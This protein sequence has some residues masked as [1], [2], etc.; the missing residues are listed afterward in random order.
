MAWD[1]VNQSHWNSLL[2]TSSHFGKLACIWH[3]AGATEPEF[4]EAEPPEPEQ[5]PEVEAFIKQP[6]SE[7]PECESAGV[8]PKQQ[9]FLE[10][11]EPPEQPDP[12]ETEQQLEQPDIQAPETHATNEHPKSS[13]AK[14]ML[15][16]PASAES[17]PAQLEVS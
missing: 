1:I 2:C 8:A 12:P 7:Q 10:Q 15:E 3:G 5:A 11:L 6:K 14:A 17:A 13:E 9:D 16:Q 4:P